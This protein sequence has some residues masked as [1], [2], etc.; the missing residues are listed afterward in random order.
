MAKRDYYAVLGVD[1]SATE[2]EIKQA[3][4]RLAREFHPDVNKAEE[5]QARF[6]EIQEAYAV[7]SDAEKRS[8]YDRLGHAGVEGS[9]GPG[10]PA[11]SVEFDFGDLNSVFDAFFGGGGGGGPGGGA[12]HRAG[13]E[14]PRARRAE[15]VT[16][17]YAIDVDFLVAVTGGTRALEIQRAGS[18]QRVDVQIPAGVRD[19]AK[20]RVRGV[21]HADPASPG[22]RG[23]LILTVSVKPHPLF[24]RGEP[25]RGE[26]E[27]DVYLDLPL[28]IEEATLGAKIEIPTPTGVATVSV[29]AGS[30]SGRKIRLRGQGCAS[31][32]AGDLY[33]IAMIQSPDLSSSGQN[34]DD[35]TRSALRRL[36]ERTD[37]R[38]SGAWNAVSPADEP[39]S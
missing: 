35:E 25:T 3:F 34:P 5:A 29:P 26:R 21:G 17:R 20:L 32:P 4:R 15:P 10:G 38:S 39:A 7:L 31:T 16:T 19:G 6:V 36:A 28:T 37:V 9:F 8:K 33:A 13:P 24:R 22:T 23:D 30:A 1:R 14:R 12:R 18:T 2:D 27:A 11:A